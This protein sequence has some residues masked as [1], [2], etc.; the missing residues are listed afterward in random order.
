MVAVPCF[1]SV[2]TMPSLQEHWNR[3]HRKGNSAAWC[4][5]RNQPGMGSTGESVGLKAKVVSVKA[6]MEMGLK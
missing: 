6:A 4:S 5:T 1:H 3:E 2:G